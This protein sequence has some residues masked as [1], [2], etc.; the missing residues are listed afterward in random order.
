[1]K[2]II[3]MTETEYSDLRISIKE[4][5][6]DLQK[7]PASFL[8]VRIGDSLQG[9]LSILDGKGCETDDSISDDYR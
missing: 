9:A 7:L 6:S 4:A 5:M 3:I 8:I 2:K 1:M